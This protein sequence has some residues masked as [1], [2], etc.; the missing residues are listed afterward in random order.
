MSLLL[1]TISAFPSGRTVSELFAIIDVDFDP[2][3]RAS[4]YAELA[5]LAD[6]GKISKGRDGR[7]RAIG[8]TAASPASS[9]K[10]L[11]D[12]ALDLDSNTLRAAP[13]IFLPKSKQVEELDDNLSNEAVTDPLALLRYYRSALRADPRGAIAQV[14][15]RHGVQWHL[16]CGAGP[17]AIEE[18]QSLLIRVGLDDL[19]DEFRKALLKREANDQALAIGWPVAVSETKGVK[20]FWPIGLISAE[21]SRNEQFLELVVDAD[22]VLVNPDWIKGAARA[23]GWTS[24]K[25]SEVFHQPEGTG[26]PFDDFLSRLK[27]AVA[28]TFK[29][30][31]SGTQLISELDKST[32]GIYNAAAIFLPT[33]STFTS[34]AVA[35]LDKIGSWSTTKIAT[36]AL[37]PLL[38]IQADLKT[39]LLHA[40]NTGP[41]NREQILAVKEAL[42]KNL[43]VVT[44]PPGTGKSQAIVSMV[45]SVLN[46]NG[47][48]LVAS[49]NHQALDAVE[50]RLREIAPETPFIVRTLNQYGS[51]DLSFSE[52]L[53]QLVKEP[54]RATQPFNPVLRSKLTTKSKIRSDAL[55]NLDELGRMQ[56][57]IAELLERLEFRNERQTP[58]HDTTSIK[59]GLFK[60][61][62]RVLFG[63]LEKARLAKV[64]DDPFAEGTPSPVIRHHIAALRTKIAAIGETNDPVDLTS[65]IAELVKLVLPRYLD[66]R[67]ILE[68]EE[69]LQLGG[70]LANYELAQS[71]G[72]LSS[73]L[74][75]TVVNHRPLWLASILGTPKRIP[76]EAGLFDL[77]IIDEASQ[78]D[79]AS[80]LPLFARAKRAVVVGDDRQLSF[81][82]QLGVAHD[83]NLMQAQ[84]LPL[85]SMGRYAQSKRS[86]FDL[87][88]LT[89]DA[90]KIMLRDQYRSATDIVGYINDAFYGGRLRV[91]GDQ[92]RMKVPSGVKPGITW[93]DVPS[94]S[95]PMVSNFNPS[96]INAIVAHLQLLLEEEQYDGS[97]GVISPFRPQVLA[98]DEAINAKISAE[99]LVKA[100]LRVGTVDS[101]QGQERDLILF[102]PCLGKS[103]AMSAVT[104]VQKD[105]RRLNVAISRARAVAHVFGD[106]SYAMSG[107]VSSLQWLAKRATEPRK[108][109]GEGAFDSEWE[110]RVYHALK[111]HGLEPVP[112]Y[113]I[114]GRRLDFALFG[115]GDIKLDL[116]IDG[117][118]WHSDADGK[119]KLADHWRD[120]QLESLGWRV[121]RFWVDE[122]AQDM[123]GCIELIRK[124]LS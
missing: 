87:A 113:E 100:D 70:E 79:I 117:R 43:T 59:V 9:N 62:W 119:R 68:E 41:L 110:R 106:L 63:K 77:L 49:K 122:L 35:D 26:L 89:P 30:K 82:S 86:V 69:R 97:V 47:S 36:T 24:K 22:D 116:E 13:A 37:A 64:Y 78:C 29:G 121:Q 53:A 84:G 75:S 18:G 55:Q 54:P 103:S 101:F 91:A 31:I 115:T 6:G 27:E 104:F 114:A 12:G 2:K 92:N 45:A 21:W 39:Q 80:A 19:A 90:T 34:G 65:E 109:V 3:K 105:W 8:R 17:L 50:Q 93:T 72:T 98:L 99:I 7:W 10:G 71:K 57:E 102:S 51:V 48:V 56:C 76:L 111:K 44:G 74:A 107:K 4:I 16:I 5:T 81:I 124:K 88:N 61:L 23:T 52:V 60:G 112:Q 11:P 32:P 95:S 58:I 108:R 118:H 40:L 14:D 33:D 85:K 120:K 46:A 15:D 20:T 1:R 123:E 83:R 96:E 28:G 66:R 25:L 73:S 42:I 38:R 67:T 94:P